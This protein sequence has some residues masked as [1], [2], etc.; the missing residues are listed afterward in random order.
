M[1]SL[2]IGTYEKNGGGG[3]VP[4]SV[5]PGGAMVPG[6]PFA[7]AANAS[8][9]VRGR[10]LVYLVDERDHGAVTVL[11][12]DD[13]GWDRLVR[14][15][16]RGAAP[17]HLTLDGDG[18]RLAAANY[19]SGSVALFGLD[20][21]GLPIEPPTVVQGSGGGP[22]AD[23]QDGPHAHCVRFSPNGE[24]LYWVDL[25]ADRIGCLTLGPI[26]SGSPVVLETVTAWRAPP[27]SGP[28]HLLFHPRRPL[29]IVVSE[30]A[31]TLTLLYVRGGGL[32]AYQAVS[33]LPA[34]FSGENLIGHMDLNFDATRI[35]VSNRG[36]D[37]IA[38]FALDGDRLAPIQHVPSG[39]AHPRH[40]ALLERERLL[41]VAHEKD[42]RIALF[43][44]A[45]DGTLAPKGEGAVIPG[46]CFVLA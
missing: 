11:R 38:V 6:T 14:L 17:C 4:L 40:F 3:L 29:A 39:G 33:T 25:G 32:Q 16:T 23:R 9:G 28:R 34:A 10:G 37:S 24:A 21:S 35:Y 7:A 31:S 42:G 1:F 19:A 15:P 46:A 22:V 18:T 30:L 8:F 20:A 12:A 44:I 43:E 26:R 41:A 2:H 27:G 13:G 45:A 5:A 36:H